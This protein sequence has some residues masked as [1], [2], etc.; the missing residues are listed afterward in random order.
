M[1]YKAAMSK[2]SRFVGRTLVKGLKK[3]DEKLSE[4]QSKEGKR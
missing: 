4:E 2:P 1:V 3:L